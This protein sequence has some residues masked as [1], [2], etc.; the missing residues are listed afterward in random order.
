MSPLWSTVTGQ[1]RYVYEQT[2]TYHLTGSFTHFTMPSS[3]VSTMKKNT[4]KKRKI[5]LL[6]TLLLQP[7]LSSSRSGP[8]DRE[9]RESEMPERK[10]RI[11]KSCSLATTGGTQA[12]N[13]RRVGP[14]RLRGTRDTECPQIHPVRCIEGCHTRT[15]HAPKGHRSSGSP[16]TLVWAGISHS[17]DYNQRA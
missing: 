9:K 10:G 5:R 6:L 16:I 4:T 1:S 15:V 12:L 3:T 14:A 7:F 8:G 2:R 13:A 17:V 11:K